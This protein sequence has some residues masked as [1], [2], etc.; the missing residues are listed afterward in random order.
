MSRELFKVAIIGRPNVGKSTLFNRLIR[1]QHAITADTPGVTRDRIFQTVEWL[2]NHFEI[3][4]TGGFSKT[5]QIAF[6]EAINGQVEIAIKQADLIIFLCSAKDGVTREDEIVADLLKKKTNQKILLVGNKADNIEKQADWIGSFYSLGFGEP[7]FISAIHGIG[8][9]QLLETIVNL[10]P[11]NQS[12]LV[13]EGTKIGLIGKPNVGKS[14]LLN[15]L[16][17]ENRM[18]ISEIAGTT[19][20]SV[21]TK[22]I[23]HDKQYIL[24]DTAG[25]KKNKQSLNDIEW[26]SELRSKL[27]INNSDLILLLIDPE[28]GLTNIDLKITKEIKDQMK[29]VVILINKVDKL[30]LEQKNQILADIKQKLIFA[31]WIETIFISALE[32]VNVNKLFNLIEEIMNNYQQIIKTPYLNNWLM[33]IQSIKRPAKKNGRDVKLTYITYNG[34]RYPHFIVFSNRPQDIHFSYLRFL[35]NQLRNVFNFRSIP[36]KISIIKK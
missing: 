16:L 3:V 35:E 22:F 33:E 24:T 7:L 5:K 21:D 9:G 4:D 10:I 18:I 19:R 1:K 12:N 25:I 2:G 31:P 6:Q 23:F 17:H 20:D 14:T 15:T 11:K 27:V 34:D 13:L 28:Q 30:A 8:I 26:Y 29:P 36:I 32:K